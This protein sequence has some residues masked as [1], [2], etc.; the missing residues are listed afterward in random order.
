AGGHTQGSWCGPHLCVRRPLGGGHSDGR[1]LRMGASIHP[2]MTAEGLGRQAAGP[3]GGVS[4][5]VTVADRWLARRIQH[6][7][8]P[9]GVRLALW[10][11]RFADGI[12]EDST[13]TS[14]R[15]PIGEVVVRD[16]RTLIGLALN[17]DLTFSDAYMTGRLE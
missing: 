13:G 4:S 1:A 14:G 2:A 10:D 5:R 17:T 16:R 15:S 8:E 3:K 12:P 6:T 7:I 9:S 11:G